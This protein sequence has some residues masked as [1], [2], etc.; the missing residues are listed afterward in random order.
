MRISIETHSIS[1]KTVYNHLFILGYRSDAFLTLQHALTSGI[2][3]AIT[4]K[5]LTSHVNVTMSR[6][7]YPPFKLD[8]YTEVLKSNLPYILMMSFIYHATVCVKSIVHEKE[9]RLKV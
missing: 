5:D 9:N 8:T 7:P 3:A 2:T 4:G 6:M 1:H